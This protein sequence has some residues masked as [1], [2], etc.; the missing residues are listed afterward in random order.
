[1]ASEHEILAAVSALHLDPE[2]VD[3]DQ[4]ADLL[5]SALSAAAEEAVEA[6]D[7]RDEVES[8]AE[9]WLGDEFDIEQALEG[10]DLLSYVDEEGLARAVGEV[11]EDEV[12]EAADFATGSGGRASGRGSAGS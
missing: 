5:H 10:V 3:V 11:V 6:M 2:K 9:R 8:I 4:V 12:G 7:L 1:M